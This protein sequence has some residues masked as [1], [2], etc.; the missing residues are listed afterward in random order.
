MVRQEIGN[1]GGWWGMPARMGQVAEK[2]DTCDMVRKQGLA[3]VVWAHKKI[4]VPELVLAN[5]G[6]GALR[7]EEAQHIQEPGRG[8]DTVHKDIRT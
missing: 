6:N 4:L 1:Q 8:L 3:S 2:M 5:M 7:P